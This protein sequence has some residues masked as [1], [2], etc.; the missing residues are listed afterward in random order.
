MVNL[1]YF[2]LVLTWLIINPLY[3]A[4]QEKVFKDK[5]RFAANIERHFDVAP[6]GTF[7]ILRMAGSI[8]IQS[9]EKN[10]VFISEKRLMNVSNKK[11]AEKILKNIDSEYRATKNS[12]AIEIQDLDE[13]IYS[14]FNIKLPKQY[15]LDLNTSG[16]DINIEAII[17][18]VEAVT[19][20]GDIEIM[21]IEGR[22]HI[23]TSGGNIE[24][25][26][27]RG[28]LNVRT[29]G[30]E[31]DIDIVTG[32]INASTSGG[33]IKVYNTVGDV[34]AETHGGSIYVTNNKGVINVETSGGEIKLENV[35]VV[36]T[37][38]TSG[39]SIYMDTSSGDVALK[40]SGGD[41]NLEQ[42]NGKAIV[43]TSGGDIEGN[44]IENGIEA[45]TS[46]GDIE[47]EGIKGPVKALTSGGDVSVEMIKSD[48]NHQDK[49]YLES[50]GGD[51]KLKIPKQMPADIKALIK[52]K[53]F[54]WKDY[55]ISSDFPELSGENIVKSKKTI[56]TSGKINGGGVPINLTTSN[57]DIKIEN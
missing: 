30:G 7:S 3:L 13:G 29:S 43:K 2:T 31:I 5:G 19:S 48:Y 10:V 26:Q 23:A 57:G 8:R 53:N 27:V 33:E 14:I 12:V 46:G 56:K 24:V 36:E 49:I 50:A 17:G 47:L 11:A 54:P 25:K 20:G 38:Y 45:I 16:G 15:A 32:D 55:M 28:D 37:A 9:W 39:G 34:E 40:T 44:D 41:I 22:V 18:S 21:E 35:G 51:V 6:K 42:V 4:G 1:K 52:L